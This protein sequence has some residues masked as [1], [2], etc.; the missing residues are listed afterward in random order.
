MRKRRAEREFAKRCK[1]WTQASSPGDLSLS[2][3]PEPF[4]GNLGD[5]L[6]SQLVELGNFVGGLK[7]RKEA[8]ATPPGAMSC[9]LDAAL[10]ET[11]PVRQTWIPG[12][13]SG[14]PGLRRRKRSSAHFAEAISSEGTQGASI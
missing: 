9:R 12:P 1:H 8:P 14:P 7:L 3:D 13:R 6:K 2:R 11:H 10:F 4:E 5:L